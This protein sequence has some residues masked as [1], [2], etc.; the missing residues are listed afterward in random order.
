MAAVAARFRPWLR[1]LPRETAALL[2]LAGATFVTGAVGVEALAAPVYA[3]WGKHTIL[4]AALV[5]VEETLEMAAIVLL[6][7]ALLG[8]AARRRLTLAIAFD[9][10]SDGASRLA[11]M[12]EYLRD[13][14]G[15][16]QFSSS[17]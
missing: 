15:E 1:T 13:H 9:D 10:R 11:L 12:M 6:I 8:H 17:P 3:L 5:A 16:L 4:H 14:V 2:V 7:A